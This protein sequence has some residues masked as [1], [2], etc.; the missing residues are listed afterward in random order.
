[1]NGLGVGRR[2]RGKDDAPPKVT[3]GQSGAL[4]S[5]P[6]PPVPA[7]Q[8]WFWMEHQQA[9]EREVDEHVAAGRV[10]VH[11]STEAFLAHLDESRA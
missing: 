3:E 6:T 7:D 8:A 9:R 1:M 2:P 4:T 11:D 5:R 10:T